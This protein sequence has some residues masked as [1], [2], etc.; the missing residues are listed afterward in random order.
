MIS[1][2]HTQPNPVPSY[3]SRAAGS[4]SGEAK[5][6]AWISFSFAHQ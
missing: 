6:L 3:G 4:S 1:I 2:S 5:K